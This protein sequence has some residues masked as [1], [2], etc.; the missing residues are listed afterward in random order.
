MYDLKCYRQQGQVQT[1]DIFYSKGSMKTKEA[2]ERR[3]LPE[4]KT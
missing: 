3:I 1:H 2:S 4:V